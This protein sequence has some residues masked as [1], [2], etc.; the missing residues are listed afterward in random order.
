MVSLRLHSREV[1][2]EN[3]LSENTLE[4]C[5]L[6]LFKLLSP[7]FLLAFIIIFNKATWRANNSGVIEVSE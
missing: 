3:L 6:L 2:L 7:C 4:A 1:Y 5:L